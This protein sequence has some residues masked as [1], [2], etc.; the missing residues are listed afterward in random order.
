M[1]AEV[2]P[3]GSARDGTARLGS[4]LPQEPCTLNMILLRIPTSR[5]R[6]RPATLAQR[7]ITADLARPHL[8]SQGADMTARVNRA[9]WPQHILTPVPAVSLLWSVAI[10]RLDQRGGGAPEAAKL[11]DK[12]PSHHSSVGDTRPA[13]TVAAHHG[14]AAS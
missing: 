7:P 13:G 10:P 11:Q 9:R 1:R 4:A 5:H 12:A 2:V 8:A 6:G 14:H 3:P